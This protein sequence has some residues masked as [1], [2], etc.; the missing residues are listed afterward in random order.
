M[1][2]KKF[3]VVTANLSPGVTETLANSIEIVDGCLILRTG[4]SILKAY[5]RGTWLLVEEVEKK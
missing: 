5:G 1:N 4:K 2:L 3:R